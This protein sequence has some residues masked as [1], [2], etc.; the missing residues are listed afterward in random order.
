LANGVSKINKK[1]LGAAC[2]VE[3]VI[4]VQ[5]QALNSS[6]TTGGEK[7]RMGVYVPSQPCK[8]K[9]LGQV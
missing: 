1:C 8:K 2:A 6:L 3:T 4:T 9:H 5:T 7:K